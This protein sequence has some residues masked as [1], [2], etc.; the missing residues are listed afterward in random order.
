L[1]LL[2]GGIGGCYSAE[3]D[4]ELDGVYACLANED[5][6]ESFTCVNWVCVDER[7]P[8]VE[9]LTPETR[10]VF[11]VTEAGDDLS[12]VLTGSGL[13]LIEPGGPVQDGFGHV[14]VMLDGEPLAELT[15]GTLAASPSTEGISLPSRPGLH[16]ITATAFRN[17]QTQY[18][19]PG[20]S[21]TTVFWIDD[22]NEHVGIA[23]PNPGSQWRPHPE[24][25]QAVIPMEFVTLNFDILN[26]NETNDDMAEGQGHVH[27]LF[28]SEKPVPE[29]I[30]TTNCNDIYVSAVFPLDDSRVSNISPNPNPLPVPVVG[31]GVKQLAI[32]AQYSTH[33]PY[34]E[35]TEDAV[36]HDA[37]DIE[38]I[39]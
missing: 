35:S 23:Q 32:V 3:F 8:L 39:E 15:S 6:G 37:F 31:L 12:I 25:L 20:A 2:L 11:D 13:T 21:M 33:D 4:A 18:P 14:S 10:T 26:P 36:V 24:T 1:A 29:C 34:P 30:E 9:I 17:D 38:I 7:G 28:D 22:Q 16:R 5:C 19:N 27:V